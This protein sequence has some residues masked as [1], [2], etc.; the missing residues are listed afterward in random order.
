MKY[1]DSEFIIEARVSYIFRFPME[2]HMVHI[3]A[4]YVGSDGTLNADYSSNPDGVAVLGF[5]FD[6][7]KEAEVHIAVDVV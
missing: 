2:M 1:F 5:L 7:T 4:K 3:N 6:V